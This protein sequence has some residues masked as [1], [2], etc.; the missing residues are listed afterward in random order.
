METILDDLCGQTKRLYEDKKFKEVE[1][2]FDTF[3]KNYDGGDAKVEAR[4]LNNRGHAKYMQVIDAAFQIKCRKKD[5][6]D[7]LLCL[8]RLAY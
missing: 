1:A 7:L 4:A 6:D 8:A 2:M 3:L 5:M